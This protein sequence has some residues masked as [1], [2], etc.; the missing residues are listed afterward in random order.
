[1]EDAVDGPPATDK[2]KTNHGVR[3]CHFSRL[4]VSKLILSSYLYFT[5]CH[6]IYDDDNDSDHEEEEEEEEDYKG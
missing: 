1:M 3:M 5:Y 6:R 4:T 2:D